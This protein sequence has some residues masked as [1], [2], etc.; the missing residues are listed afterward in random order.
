MLII[1]IGLPGTGKTTFSR[2]LSERIGAL[3]LNTDII[4]DSI[5][6][7]GQY[8]PGTKA[9]VYEQ[10]QR[11]CGEALATGQTVVVDGTFYQKE[12]RDNF[13]RVAREQ[14]KAAYW[15]QLQADEDR[16]RERVARKRTYSEADFD[17]YLK[18]K[19]QFEP[20]QR[21]CLYLTTNRREDLNMLLDKAIDYIGIVKSD[22]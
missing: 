17:V 5:G 14:Q 22:P 8:D 19:S 4:R 18:I 2:A 11:R 6:K 9:L 10:M 12:A 3:H 16:I 21:E 13:E 15:I 7:R 20:L 1:V